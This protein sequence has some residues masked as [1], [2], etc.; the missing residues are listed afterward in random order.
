[1]HKKLLSYNDIQEEANFNLP[2]STDNL[3]CN[4][5]REI[6]SNKP[7]WIVSN[8]IGLFFLIILCICSLSFFIYY[9]DIINAPVRILGKNLPKQIISRTEG[10]LVSLNIHE[11]SIVKSGDV[12]A[13]LQSN[14]SYNEV[15]AL[16]N[17]IRIVEK[18]IS[19]ETIALIPDLPKLFNLGDLQKNY[20]EISNQLYQLDWSSPNGYFAQ[21]K[22]NIQRDLQVLSELKA[23]VDKQKVLISKDLALQENLLRINDLLVK[24][25]V[26]A[27]LDL[28]KDQSA[29][30]SRQQQLVQTDAGSLNQNVSIIAKENELIEIEKSRKD[31]IQNFKSAL[32]NAKSFIEDWKSK[33]IVFASESGKI[34]FTSYFQKNS[35]IKQGQELFYILPEQPQYFAE[36]QAA[37]K[38]FGKIQKG[39]KVNIALNGFPRNE[40]GILKG[41]VE[42]IPS[43]PYKDT[44]FLLKVELIKGLHTNY[45]KKLHFTNSLVGTAEI[46][47]SDATLAERLLYQWRD[48]LKRD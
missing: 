25:K 30:I 29:V 23:N 6:I 4:E 20:Q 38:N 12:L 19:L 33:Y 2:N 45:N 18:K 44:C 35:L 5:V 8:G 40:F 17:W 22:Q 42:F 31:I 16:E 14:A 37:Q 3:Y 48:L 26:L 10:K 34:Q 47:T 39:Q 28:N 46:I 7:V 41:V 32:F 36:V 11:N 15:R 21:R 24:E 13:I 43:V 1:M 9:P 27:P